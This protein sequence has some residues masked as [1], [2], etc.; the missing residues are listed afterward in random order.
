MEGPNRLVIHIIGSRTALPRNDF[1]S[2]N[3]GGIKAMRS[4]Q[5]SDDVVRVVFELEALVPYEIQAGEGGVRIVLQNNSG[6]FEPWT[7]AML[8]STESTVAGGGPDGGVRPG[9]AD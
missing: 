5:F 8:G 2:T 9:G 1:P 3:R 6:P 4:S 7:S